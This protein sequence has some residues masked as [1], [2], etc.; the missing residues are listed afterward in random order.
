MRRTRVALISAGLLATGLLVAAPATVHADD[1]TRVAVPGL[2]DPAFIV[3]DVDGVPH[4]K[5]KNA[6][7]L[8]FVNGW[9]HADD[10]LFQMDLTRKRASGRAAELLGSSAIP[11]DVQMRT[12]GVRR[13]VERSFQ[14]QSRETREAL[15]AYAD[16]VNS[17]IA[18]NKLP[19][20]YAAVQVTKVEPWTVL[21]S[22]TVAKILAFSLSFDLDI[23]RTAQV[24]AYNAA[25]FDGHAAV[26]KDVSPFA[27]FTNASP[28]FDSTGKPADPGG[29]SRPVESNKGVSGVA[30]KL[31]ADYLKKAE[32]TP[33]LADI[34]R[35]D[36]D[37]GSNSWVIGG[38][39][40]ATGRPLLASDPHLGQ[41]APSI[42]H[43]IGYDG[44]G[45]NVQGVSVPGAPFIV[46]GQNR[47]IA[48]G[49]TQHAVDVSDTYVEQVRPDPASPSGLST[50][51]KG[52]LEPVV[53]ID[54]SY[55][56]NARTP[57][58][59][60]A[61]TPVPA[62]GGIPAQTYIVPRRNNGPLL[63]VDQATGTALSVQYTGYSVTR[64]LDAFR[65]LDKARNYDEFRDALTLFDMGGQHFVYA[66]IKG[67]IA[68]LTNT[69]VPI[70]E[71][72]QAGK[73]N[74]N[75]PYL[76]RNGTG[77][78]EWL[79]VAN[80]QPNQAVPYEIVPNS[81]LPQVVNPPA[82]FIV[83]ANNDPTGN[84]FDNDMLNQ[85]RPGGG[86]SYLGFLHT[87]TRAGRITDML[88][89]AVAKGRITSDDVV[90]MQ[91]DTS[92]VDGRLFT[93]FITGALKRAKGSKN[94]ELTALAADPR[95][96]EAVNR[97]AKWDLTYPTGIPEGYDGND[98]NGKLGKPSQHEIDNSVA[99]TLYTLWRGRFL[100]N[101]FD[102]H[103]AQISPKLPAPA[104]FYALPA[105]RQLLV[106][107]D[108]RKGVGRSG[109][110]FFAVPD[111]AD[112]D[113]RR[114]LLVLRS[115]RDALNLAAGDDFAKAFGN[116]TDQSAY[117]WGKLHRYNFPSPLGAPYS[118]PSE[119]NR[120]T[121]PLPGLPGIPAD[122]GAGIVDASS[123]P[124]R[125]DSPDR[126]TFTFVPVRRGVHQAT[127]L[128]MRGVDSL[129]GGSSEDLG[130]EFEQNLLPGWLTND[131]YPIRMY[132]S[133]LK[134]ATH[135]VTQFAPLRQQ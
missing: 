7:D 77:G 117:R 109:I 120:F 45:Y 99:A 82:G 58:R 128:G 125:A 64:E 37:R 81:E 31:A 74:G 134:G 112:P 85:L 27:A 96:A 12:L 61:I 100:I 42:M 9:V 49:S 11:G 34:L 69:E 102:K 16:G 60:D 101:V 93:P 133:D 90:T 39:H 40:T 97:L 91:S 13:A 38:R 88:R 76:L 113:D 122:G 111:V 127:P 2:R 6:H 87:G 108:E 10:R 29:G 41:E 8:F 20:Q 78:N 17:W 68:Y 115:V 43:P 66:D 123:H 103:L 105:I 4:I 63:S 135:S 106:D 79:P 104:D 18:R 116:S 119:G 80:R 59:Q 30:A 98:R 110:D 86:I 1:T 124:I 75:P 129:F 32:K 26:F 36:A 56:V 44:G 33:L 107:F 71:D 67:N 51:Y 25:G 24:Q 47:D 92:S 114:D 35:R 23:D 15:K 121:S 46:L 72:L 65:L 14:A 118:V 89:A 62:G 22:L 48:F 132:P 130:G 28:V 70:R 131:T 83:S 95:V 84:S 5:A 57:G 54:E 3:R 19:S 126:F 21:D 53:A 50:L 52:K 73:V 94:A 55:R